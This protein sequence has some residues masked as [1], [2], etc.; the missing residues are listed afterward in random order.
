MLR[1]LHFYGLYIQNYISHLHVSQLSHSKFI[2]LLIY[3]ST[4]KVMVS[5][6]LSLHLVFFLSNGI[7]LLFHVFSF[8]CLH[9][10][11]SFFSSSICCFFISFLCFSPSNLQISLFLFHSFLLSKFQLFNFNFSLAHPILSKPW[12]WCLL[13]VVTFFSNNKSKLHNSFST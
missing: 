11:V 3:K 13:L 12:N 6:L 1:S 10:F 9:F 4:L 5:V 8:L 2:T 7:S